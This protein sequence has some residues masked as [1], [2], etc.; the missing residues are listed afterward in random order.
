MECEKAGSTPAF[1]FGCAAIWATPALAALR[2][3]L[4]R[5]WFFG[6]SIL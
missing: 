1:L 5:M 3:H 6:D 4:P 2:T